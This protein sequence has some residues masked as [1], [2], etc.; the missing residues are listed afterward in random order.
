[1]SIYILYFES[2]NYCGYGHHAIV[3]ADDHEAAAAKAW[4]YMDEYF[5]EQDQDQYIEENGEDDGVM[6]AHLVS[7][8]VL[9]KNHEYWQYVVDSNQAS[10]YEFIGITIEELLNV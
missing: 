3:R 8:E 7:N 4:P 5:R 6:W 1:M 10:F 9:D 2:A